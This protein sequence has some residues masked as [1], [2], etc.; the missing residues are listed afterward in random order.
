M[1]SMNF[2]SAVNQQEKT[3]SNELIPDGWVKIKKDSHNNTTFKYGKSVD[4]PVIKY[5]EQKDIVN[6]VNKM[7]MRHSSY[8]QQDEEN[9]Y[10]NYKFSWESDSEDSLQLSDS[11]DNMSDID[12]DF[13]EDNDD[14]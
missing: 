1:S 10:T 6:E 3:I 5:L 14:Y 2:I 9:L 4:N 13:D 7:I 8:K 12:D 11:E